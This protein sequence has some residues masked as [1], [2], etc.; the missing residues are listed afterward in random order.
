MDDA[1]KERLA[2]L[3]G[4]SR[5]EQLIAAAVQA[6]ASRSVSASPLS[7]EL[8]QQKLAELRASSGGLYEP[9]T[10]IRTIIDEFI[11]SAA[12]VVVADWDVDTHPALLVPGHALR[13]S[14]EELRRIYPDGFSCCGAGARC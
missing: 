7:H 6:W 13:R 9:V 5:R 10:D 8:Q 12:V 3:R 11:G 1:E 4:K 14:E 2:E